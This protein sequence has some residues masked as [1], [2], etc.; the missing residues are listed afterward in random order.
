MK[1][2]F[3][4][5]LILLSF[6]AFAQIENDCNDVNKL[7]CCPSLEDGYEPKIPLVKDIHQTVYKIAEYE[8]FP[9]LL[10]Y[11]DY[12]FSEVSSKAVQ[13]MDNNISFYYCIPKTRQRMKVNITDF[14]DPFYETTNGK[15][16]KGID[17]IYFN[18]PGAALSFGAH[19]VSPINKKY[20]K[21][22][23]VS[24]RFSPYGGKEDSV[25]FLAY[26]NDRYLIAITIDDKP[27]RFTEPLQVEEFIKEYVSQI[28]LSEK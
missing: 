11:K 7:N 19:S 1:K 27:K 18:N 22:I 16:S 21:S 6:S 2:I 24:S 25:S 17:L 5:P 13:N 26:V 10:E 23:I 4:I 20:K 8:M 15:A 14:S 12:I 3:L 9:K 28:N